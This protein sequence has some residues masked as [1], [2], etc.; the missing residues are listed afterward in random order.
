M[1]FTHVQ[2]DLTWMLSEG[3]LETIKD[4]LSFYVFL[5]VI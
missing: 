3:L 1:I 4:V 2:N 5:K